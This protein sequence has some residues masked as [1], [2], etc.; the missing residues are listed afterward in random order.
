MADTETARTAREASIGDQRHFVGNALAVERRGRGQHFPHSRAAFWSLIPDDNDVAFGIRPGLDRGESVFFTI[1]DPGGS[2]MF[3][4]FQSCYFYNRPLRR[5]RPFEPNDASGIRQ[6]IGDRTHNFLIGVETH[7]LNIFCQ[8]FAGN[9]DAVA[10]QESTVE[11]RTHEHR[12]TAGLPHVFGHETAAGLQIRKIGR[13]MENIRDVEQV[14]IDAR[15][16]C[17]G[18]QM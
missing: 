15:F 2:A 16:V 11:K 18:G 5:Q 7:F 12:H 9:G 6:G 8:R 4:M 10:V 17:H 13:A 3:Q 14:E 1:E